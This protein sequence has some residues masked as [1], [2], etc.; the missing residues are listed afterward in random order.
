M[1]TSR[2]IV[3]AAGVLPRAASAGIRN[4]ILVVQPGEKRKKFPP[5]L[6]VLWRAGA[7]AAKSLPV[8]PAGIMQ[9]LFHTKDSAFIGKPLTELYELGTQRR[10]TTI[11]FHGRNIARAAFLGPRGSCFTG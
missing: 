11:L 9:E 7:G 6:E 2:I 4:P 8:H 1:K 5:L 10:D 3:C